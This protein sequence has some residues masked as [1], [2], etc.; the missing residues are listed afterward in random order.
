MIGKIKTLPAGAD[1]RRLD[2][3]L[4]GPASERVAGSF[5]MNMASDDA[6]HIVDLMDAQAGLSRRAKKP[7]L[8]IS[9]SYAPTDRVTPAQMQQDAARILDGLGMRG[10]QAFAVIHDD[11]SYQHFHLVIS[12]VD[13][14]GRCV[15][16][17][18]SKRKIEKVLRAIEA[19]RDLQPV[20]GRLA[21]TPSKERFA[22]P[23]AAQRGYSQPPAA[24]IDAMQS[25]R[26]RAELDARLASIGWR[27]EAA[28]PRPGQRVGGLILR[29]PNGERAKASACGRDC[30]GPALSRRFSAGLPL[31]PT[32]QEASNGASVVPPLSRQPIGADNLAKAIRQAKVK[33]PRLPSVRPPSATGIIT[34]AIRAAIP[35]PK[36]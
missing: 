30:S 26:S 3:Y 5:S 11:K 12:R 34:R 8:H 31:P 15:S 20:P 23:K 18:N 6:A 29:G 10:H 22:G 27:L 2:A 19:E 13:P 28:P 35:L 16:D 14:Y 33:P 24:V 1:L 21:E 32:S 25:A 7:M 17:S 4:R 9:V 36:L